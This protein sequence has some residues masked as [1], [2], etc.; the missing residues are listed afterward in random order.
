ML[1]TFEALQALESLR[2]DLDQ[3]S[4]EWCTVVRAI[5]DMR[6]ML[7]LE[8]QKMNTRD[9]ELLSSAEG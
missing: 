5:I 4:D 2:F 9:R 1:K 8:L 7:V 3:P 6:A